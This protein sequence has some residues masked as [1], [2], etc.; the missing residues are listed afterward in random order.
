MD[1]FSLAAGGRGRVSY[2]LQTAMPRKQGPACGQSWRGAVPR[3]ACRDRADAYSNRR[4]GGGE[5]AQAE[6]NRKRKESERASKTDR[7]RPGRWE[8]QVVWL[9]VDFDCTEY[10]VP[11]LF[12]CRIGNRPRRSG[13]GSPVPAGDRPLSGQ[14]LAPCWAVSSTLSGA[15]CGGNAWNAQRGNTTCSGAGSS[16]Q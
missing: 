2:K 12:L 1:E 14:S 16:S 8:G 6:A 15:F 10:P 13:G 5:S 9:S 7:H 11:V 3:V 4:V